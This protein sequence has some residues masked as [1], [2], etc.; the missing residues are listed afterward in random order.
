MSTTTLFTTQLGL[1]LDLIECISVSKFCVLYSNLGN[2]KLI[3][4]FNQK[5]PDVCDE[6]LLQFCNHLYIRAFNFI[7]SARKSRMH[8]VSIFTSC[9]MKA[10]SF[11]ID[12]LGFS[13]QAGWRSSW[14]FSFRWLCGGDGGETARCLVRQ[15]IFRQRSSSPCIQTH[16]FVVERPAERCYVRVCAARIDCALWMK[17]HAKESCRY[18][19]SPESP[20]IRDAHQAQRESHQSFGLWILVARNVCSVTMQILS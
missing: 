12:S 6:L 5:T 3:N 8:L 18:T 13:L 9:I 16:S 10:R 11:R 15:L 1:M 14:L 7:Y 19:P 17:P 2:N 4:T 20:I